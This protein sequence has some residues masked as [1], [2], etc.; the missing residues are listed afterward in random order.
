MYLSLG[1]RAYSPQGTKFWWLT[2]TSCHFSHLLLISI[3]DDN[4]FWK[5]HCFTFFPYKSIRDQI[6]MCCKIGQGQARVIIWIYLVGLE[7]QILHTKFQ[8]H[9][10]FGSLFLRFLPYMGLT[11]IL[12]MW[13]GCLNKPS[14]PHP[15]ETPYEIWLQSA[16]LVL[17]RRCLKS[18]DDRW[19]NDRRRRQ[20]YPIS[21]PMS[22]R[23]R[24]AKNSTHIQHN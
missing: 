9:H 6:W 11:A 3:T 4:S 17:R 13:P 2:E 22:F 24:W 8:G 19:T 1:Q 15:M 5:I 23:L 20:T 21:S 16:Q 10:L 7:H 14:L 12:V 18:V